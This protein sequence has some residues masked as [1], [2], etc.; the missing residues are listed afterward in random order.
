M[1][2]KTFEFNPLGVN[3]YVLSDETKECVVIDAACFY[4]D[5]KE[6]LLNYLFDHDFVVKHLLNT[7]LHFDHIFGV[8]TLASQFELTLE[9]HKADEFLLNDIPGQLRLFGIPNSN[10]NYKPEIGNYLNDQ[11]IIAFGNQSLKVIHTPGHS[12]GSVVFYSEDAGCVFSG[13]AL[14]YT[15]IGRTDLPGGSYDELLDSIHSKLFSLPDETVVYC[16]HGPAT[17]I[18]FEKKNN[19]FAGIAT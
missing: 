2:I 9:C 19:S 11:D 10:S 7:H 5:E 13:D 14:F 17:T 3:T 12:P 16:G 18:G 4:A 8:N 1:K 15:S 6:I